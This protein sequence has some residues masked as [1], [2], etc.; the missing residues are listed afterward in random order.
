ME[1]AT[2]PRMLHG[3]CLCGAVAYRLPD[4]LA[5]AGYCHCSDCRRFSGSAFSAFGGIAESRFEISRGADRIGHYDKSAETQLGFCRVCG[6]SL[7]ARKP[8]RGM[9]HLRLGTLDDT[10]SLAP[11]AHSYFDSKATWF[12][13]CDTLPRYATSR[14]AGQ[15]TA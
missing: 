3:R 13:P 12:M 5:Y 4:D 2:G 1:P 6:S 15:P 14:A 10:P 11:Q 9:I 8:A 7:Y